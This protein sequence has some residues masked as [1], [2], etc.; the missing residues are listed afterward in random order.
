LA[1][2]IPILHVEG[3]D[4]ISVINALLSRHGID[5]ERGKRHLSIQDMKSDKQ[6]L[7]VM[8]DA[9]KAATDKSVGFVVDI[10]IQL[11]QRWQAVTDRL[12]TIG[13]NAPAICP[14]DGFV[15][16]MPNYPNE[17]GIWLMPD[18]VTDGQ[19]L[20]HLIETLL[21]ANDPLWQHAKHCTA[22][23]IELVDSANQVIPDGQRKW[24]RFGDHE[25]I[26]AEV[27][28]WLAWQQE[29]GAPLGAAINDHI[30]GHDS[31][32]AIAFLQWTKRLFGFANLAV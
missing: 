7:S 22:R 26:K 1:D 30:L 8:P 5:T 18:C 11:S 20:E 19:M 24:R 17:F 3:K 29:P 13:V 10:D 27:H 21:P 31:P 6:L 16:R 15:G 25:R 4:D 12:S 2:I 9:I 32:Q 28:S 23:T 14:P